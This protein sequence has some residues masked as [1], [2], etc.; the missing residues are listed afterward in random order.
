MIKRF[1]KD[2]DIFF[3]SSKENKNIF[4][5]L[6][7]PFLLVFVF[8]LTYIYIYDSKLD[9][10]GDNFEYINLAKSLIQGKGYALPYSNDFPPS[11]WFP[12]GY[13]SILAGIMLIMGTSISALKIMNGLLFLAGILIMYRLI[14]TLYNNKAL[15]FTLALLV[16][17]NCG[18][19]RFS[20]IIMSEIPYLFFSLLTF[21]Y[22][23]KLNEEIPF[24]KSKYFYGVLL[25]SVATYYLRN[26]GIVLVAAIAMQWLL[27][28]KWKQAGVYII[29]FVLLYLP[30]I[31]RNSMLGLKSR[32]VSTMMAAN[33]WRP[34]QGELNTVGS[35]LDKML[36]NFVDTVVKG[37]AEVVFPFINPNETPFIV[38]IGSVVLILTF[39]GAWKLKRYRTL[40]L[41]YLLGN[42]AIFLVWHE[43]NS[44]RYVWPLAPFLTIC[45]LG[46]VYQVVV[47]LRKKQN[48]LAPH[49]LPYLL[50]PLAVLN[51][52]GLKQI[53]AMA[54]EKD[55]EPA[56]RNYFDM[57]D[58]VKKLNNNQLMVACRKPGMFH[59][60]SDGFVT[61]YKDTESDRELITDLIDKKVD[62]LVL[63]KLGY[64]SVYRYLRPAV[65]KN[66]D[67]FQVVYFK[68]NPNT[69]LLKFDIEKAKIKF[70]YGLS[71][72]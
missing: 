33:A 12:P 21:Y 18:L 71:R 53:H 45:L 23:I 7:Q 62:Y 68:E 55:Y 37:F 61:N 16:T 22:V 34:E 41:F 42:I 54:M 4:F 5:N 57:A 70:N 39:I 46:G 60:F 59:Y 6:F 19:L 64:S 9:L 40:F 65:E 50:L 32:Y 49:Y 36:T 38:L 66:Q 2:I 48:K 27:E 17:L 56:Y 20:T 69:F 44:S 11:N 8:V 47:N 35:F 25:S 63:E 10:N 29:G 72:H 14:I 31:I 43:G 58:Y 1:S 26:I 67:L 24:Y 3:N 15:A 51:A 28:K 52:F 13:S 30:W